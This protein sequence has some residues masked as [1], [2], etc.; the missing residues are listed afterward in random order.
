M[1]L[2]LNPFI[3]SHHTQTIPPP[4][5]HPQYSITFDQA[6]FSWMAETRWLER[7]RQLPIL[8]FPFRFRDRPHRKRKQPKRNEQTENNR[9]ACRQDNLGVKG[10]F[11]WI[12]ISYVFLLLKLIIYVFRCFSNWKKLNQN[13]L[14]YP[15]QILSGYPPKT[16]SV[17]GQ[18][19]SLWLF[20]S[21]TR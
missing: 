11:R 15:T 20:N 16:Y 1:V 17:T 5:W 21:C 10:R 8:C 13:L 18:S 2:E 3:S 7:E 19:H 6:I 9:K 14:N 12:E 4:Q